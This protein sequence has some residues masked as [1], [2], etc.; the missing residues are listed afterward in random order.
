MLDYGADPTGMADSQAAFAAAIATE[1]RVVVPPGTYLINSP[2]TVDHGFEL[3]G[4]GGSQTF[5]HRG[6]SGASDSQG[7]FNLVSGATYVSMSNM[8][9]RSLS[10][11]T[12]GCLISVV[13]TDNVQSIGT[14]NFTNLDLTTTGNETHD[15]TI[16]MDG[17]ARTSA[18][19]GIRHV[20][21]FACKVFGGKISTILVKS[22]L[23][24]SF[25]G[26][27]VFTA[28]GSA[29]SN[30]RFDGVSGVETQSFQF[31]PADCSCPISFDR[32]KLGIFSCGIMGN[33]TNTAN[34]ENVYGFG[35][36]GNVQQNWGNSMFFDTSTGLKMTVNQ[37]IGNTGAASNFA[38]E[39]IGAITGSLKTGS[40]AQV[41]QTG[42]GYTTVCPD[43]QTFG[44]TD[45]SFK[46][47]TISTGGG[48][49]AVVFADYKSAT[50][51]LLANPSGEFQASSSP[52]V[53]Y[54]GIFKS[55]TSHQ[56][57]VKNNTGSTVTYSI[58][59][60]GQVASTTDPS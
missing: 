13:A 44:F 31:L 46:L 6:F 28:G 20:D 57:S 42:V 52:S 39:M 60:M 34:T 21:M 45:Q 29:T 30:I 33:V 51:T 36:S 16:Y 14:Y 50:I 37:K 54:T 24:F 53:G 38:L 22:V 40:V 8:T 5:I 55:A 43:T 12:G 47:F 32:A 58:L 2:I 59:N 15:Y 18:P 27:G 48:A 26:G 19:I 3:I 41:G 11:Q 35:F 1:N 10:G 49:G 23:K 4:S 25:T 7:I 17:T 9:M 56:I